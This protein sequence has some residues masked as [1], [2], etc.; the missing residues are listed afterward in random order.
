MTGRRSGQLFSHPGTKGQRSSCS[1]ALRRQHS[2]PK[3][4]VQLS[5]SQFGFISVFFLSTSFMGKAGN[6]FH[7]EKQARVDACFSFS[8]S[9]PLKCCGQSCH[10]VC[11]CH[12]SS[13]DKRRHQFWPMFATGSSSCSFSSSL[14]FITETGCCRFESI[15]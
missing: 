11:R 8:V 6:P 12:W 13:G 10:L 3:T 1:T 14:C 7:K 9:F 5:L 15:T 2:W 4:P